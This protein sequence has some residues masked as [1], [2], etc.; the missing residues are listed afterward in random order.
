MLK[1][2]QFI[3]ERFSLER[4][5]ARE[6]QKLRLIP[7]DNLSASVAISNIIKSEIR[8]E[9]FNFD[10]TIVG[11]MNLDLSKT[12]IRNRFRFNDYYKRFFESRS[13]GFHFEGLIAGL[14]GGNVSESL[15]TPYD[16][17]SEEGKISCKVVRDKS[18]SVVLKGVNYSLSKYIKE[19]TGS[20]ENLALLKQ[21]LNEPNP[22]SYLLSIKNDDLVNIAEDLIDELLNNIDGLLIGVPKKDFEIELFYFDKNKIKLILLTP[23]MTINPKTK[24]SK[25]IRFSTKI[26]KLTDIDKKAIQGSIKFPFISDK[27]YADFLLGNKETKKVLRYL[28]TFGDRYGVDRL[29]ANIPQDLVVDLS[30]NPQFFSDMETFLN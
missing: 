25:Q 22:I 11:M 26:F 19:Y 3:N 13:R 9:K 29:G 30:K 18:E 7:L 28:N 6:L 20:K 12:K 4:I 17:I 2:S 1:F 23:G 8:R 14:L 15:D 16:V 24:G 27:E 21:L 10:R 5:K